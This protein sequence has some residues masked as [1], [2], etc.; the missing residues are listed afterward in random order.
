MSVSML[1]E[2][3]A[4]ANVPIQV[5]TT[6]ANGKTEL[7]VVPG[8][9]VEV[10]GVNVVY[11]SRLTKDHSH[12]SP[13]LLRALWKRAKEFDVVHIHAWWN[14]VSIFSCLVALMRKVPVIVSPRGTLSEYSFQNKNVTIK[15]LIHQL[16]GKPLLKRCTIHVTSAQELHRVENSIKPGS[17]FN[18]PNFVK[19]PA[20]HSASRPAKTV[21]LKLIFLSRIEEKKGLDLLI[22]ALPLLSF[23]YS[24]TIVGDGEA[25]Y[26]SRLRELAQSNGTA[27]HVRW[28]G[29]QGDSKFDLLAEHDLF[30]LPSYDE[31][32]GN[33]V[34]ESLSQGTAVLISKTTGLA[35][36]VADNKLGWLCEPD[37]ISVSEQLNRINDER[38][39][40]TRIREAAPD[41]IKQDYNDAELVKRYIEMYKLTMANV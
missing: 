38:N 2:R 12:Y 26:V 11:F 9:P 39:E 33:T 15:K 36:Y 22:T 37:A 30:I 35:D 21:H 40:L 3:L 4:G 34:I 25:G 10:D 8:I 32:F 16:L 5:F 24:L 31:N 29:F 23:S 7:P 41:K 27:E 1:S 14:L 20:Q 17:A 19:L 6:T 13:A 28:M 18:L